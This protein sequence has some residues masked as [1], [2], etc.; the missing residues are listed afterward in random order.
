MF[1]NL[2]IPE[3]Y[4]HVGGDLVKSGGNINFEELT[5]AGSD[6]RKAVF[7]KLKPQIREALDLLVKQVFRS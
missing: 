1:E 2:N 4:T 7:N 5:N 6:F 3:D